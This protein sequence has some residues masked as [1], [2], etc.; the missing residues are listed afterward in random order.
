MITCGFSHCPGCFALWLARVIPLI[1]KHTNNL[2]TTG[3]GDRIMSVIVFP[4]CFFVVAV[5]FQTVCNVFWVLNRYFAASEITWMLNE[6]IFL[7]RMLVYPFDN[8]S[9]FLYYFVFG[10][11]RLTVNVF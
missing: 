9:Y 7:L 4:L 3:R 10:W 11:G 6:G 1:L 8:E 2:F 5:L